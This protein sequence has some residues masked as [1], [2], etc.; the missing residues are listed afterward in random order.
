M[1][2]KVKKWKADR[3]DWVKYYGVKK[4]GQIVYSESESQS[5]KR[6]GEQ[7]RQQEEGESRNLKEI[8]L[9]Q[10]ISRSYLKKRSVVGTGLKEL[11]GRKKLS[12]ELI[13]DKGQLHTFAT[14]AASPMRFG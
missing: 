1:A 8:K 11:E 5:T 6:A 14:P 4:N 13:S 3:K 10:L 2:K 7:N 12:I 9:K